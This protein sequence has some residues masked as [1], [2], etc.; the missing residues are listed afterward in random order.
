[1]YKIVKQNR[2]HYNEPYRGKTCQIVGVEPGKV[3]KSL[4]DAKHDLKLLSAANPIGFVIID[5]YNNV[6][7]D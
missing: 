4:E 5:K 3:Y 1:M 6:I 2:V 7:E